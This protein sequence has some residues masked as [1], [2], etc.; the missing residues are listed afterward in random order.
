MFVHVE[1]GGEE[2][3]VAIPT[4]DQPAAAPPNELPVLFSPHR[5]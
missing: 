3:K 2:T 5:L 4:D 1:G